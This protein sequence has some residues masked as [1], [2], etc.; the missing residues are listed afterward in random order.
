MRISADGQEA[1]R[2]FPPAAPAPAAWVLLTPS[3]VLLCDVGV[4][5]AKSEKLRGLLFWTKLRQNEKYTHT[6][7]TQTYTRTHAHVHSHRRERGS[8][9]WH[10]GPPETA[11]NKLQVS[12][13]LG[14]HLTKVPGKQRE[15]PFCILPSELDAWGSGGFT[16]KPY[17]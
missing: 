15:S 14:L 12:T 4:L 16:L 10:S 9:W 8:R 11:S 13:G 17:N 7:Q 5:Y 3:T 2:A 1:H 6:G